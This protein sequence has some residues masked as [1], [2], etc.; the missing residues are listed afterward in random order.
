MMRLATRLPVAPADLA[1][2]LQRVSCATPIEAAAILVALVEETY[3]LVEVHLPEV[4]VAR[5]RAIFRF[6]RR[7]Y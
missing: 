1:E 4:D 3:D 2:R 7:A 5:L 6:E